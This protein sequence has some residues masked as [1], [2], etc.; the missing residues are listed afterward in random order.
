MPKMRKT[1]KQGGLNRHQSAEHE[2][3]YTKTCKEKL[4]LDIFEQ[5][6]VISKVKLAIDQC[7]DFRHFLLIKN[8]SKTLNKL[9]SL[10]LGYKIANHVLGY[11]S[12]GSLEKESVVQFNISL[13][14]SA[15]KKN[16]LCFI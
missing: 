9:A 6:L 13:Q 5:F 4:P 8:V 1:I 12:G 14:I 2:E 15:T 16:Q 11:I 7:F 10:L 3:Q